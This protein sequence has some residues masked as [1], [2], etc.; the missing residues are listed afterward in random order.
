MHFKKNPNL[1]LQYWNEVCGRDDKQHIFHA[2]HSARERGGS[3]PL[4]TTQAAQLGLVAITQSVTLRPATLD[5][6]APSSGLATSSL[7]AAGR[8]ALATG[9]AKPSRGLPPEA[10]MTLRPGT[11]LGGLSDCGS[12]RGPPMRRLVTPSKR[13]PAGCV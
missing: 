4:S 12:A 10:V 9:G 7:R 6:S 3:T 13:I 5:V 1:G 2:M 11:G 8:T